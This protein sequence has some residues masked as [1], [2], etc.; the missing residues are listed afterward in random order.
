MFG[1]TRK[2]TTVVLMALTVALVLVLML[3]ATASA[4]GKGP[5]VHRVSVGGPD[6]CEAWGLSPGCDANWSLVAIQHADGSVSG[7]FID[8]FWQ[9]WGFHATIDCLYVEGND[10]WVSGEITN[11]YFGGEDRIGEHF[12]ARVR[13]NG[14]SANDPAD[15][16]SYSHT[17]EGWEGHPHGTCLEQP[18]YELFDVPQGQV[19]VK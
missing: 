19:V 1:I 13:D 3:A 11:G 9:G 15:Q 7:Q 10:A 5:V 17:G 12:S 14:T 18:D 4:A 8:R 2:R 16:F 6:A